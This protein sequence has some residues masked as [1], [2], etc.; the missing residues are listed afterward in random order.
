MQLDVKGQIASSTG[1]RLLV[2]T[3]SLRSTPSPRSRTKSAKLPVYFEYAS[4]VTGCDARHFPGQSRPGIASGR[5]TSCRSRRS[6]IY[7]INAESTPTSVTVH[8]NLLLGD[9]VFT[10]DQFPDLRAFYGKFETKDQ[11]PVVLKAV[12]TAASGN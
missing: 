9:I 10:L 6:A 4:S 2:P 1:K 5:R 12:G 7:A 3:I 8:R 11:E